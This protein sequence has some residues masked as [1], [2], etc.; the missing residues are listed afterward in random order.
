MAR[1]TWEGGRPPEGHPRQCQRTISR[2][3]VRCGKWAMKGSRFCRTHGGLRRGKHKGVGVEHLPRFYGNQLTT[4]LQAAIDQQTGLASHEVVSLHEELALVRHTAG[5]A[6]RLYA[7]A[8]DARDRAAA[9]MPAYGTAEYS[10]WYDRQTSLND[11]VGSAGSLMVRAL[12]DVEHFASSLAKL[13]AGAKDQVNIHTLHGC[14]RQVVRLMFE[15]CGVENQ[16]LAEELER[17]VREEV[18]L[19]NA[20]SADGT[21]LTPDMVTADVQSMDAMVPEA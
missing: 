3:G 18:V 9:E 17:R 5:E 4:T 13:E 14:M 6:V 2:T 1:N 10:Q 20:G 19:P 7:V 11:S 12:K 21:H 16:H 15:V 8:V